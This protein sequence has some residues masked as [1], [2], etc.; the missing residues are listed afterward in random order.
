MISATVTL[1]AMR[2]SDDAATRVAAMFLIDAF[3]AFS[4]GAPMAKVATHLRQASNFALDSAEPEFV[5]V[6]IV[7]S[8]PR[9]RRSR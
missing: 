9:I 2:A 1:K 8:T 3:E 4:S 7:E 5:H 6:A